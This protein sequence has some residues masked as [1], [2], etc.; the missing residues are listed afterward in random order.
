L[1]R[2]DTFELLPE[3]ATVLKPGDRVLFVGSDLTR[4]LQRRY[5]T[6]PGTV[7][8]VLSGTEPPRSLFFRWLQ[9]RARGAE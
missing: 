4:R 8:W 1:E 5:L 7:S 9:Q 2:G 6:E 3:I